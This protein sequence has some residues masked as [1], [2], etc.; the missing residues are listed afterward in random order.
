[1]ASRTQPRSLQPDTG[2]L[3]GLR[4]LAIYAGLAERGAHLL[5]GLLQG[6]PPRQW[7]HYPEDDAV[8]ASGYLWF[9]HAH[10][11][12]DRPGTLEHG[13]V[14]LFARRP[15]WGRRLRS[16]AEQSFAQLCGFPQRDPDTRHLLAIG[17]NAKGLPISLFTVNSWVT[18]DLMLGAAL[19]FELLKRMRLDTGHAEIDGVIEAVV[20]LGLDELRTLLVRR[21]ATL[22]AH[23]GPDKL[24]DERLEL[25][26]EMPLDLDAKL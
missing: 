16:R 25:L 8:D 10:S 26:S 9:Y 11:Q 14:H 2:R 18:G 1:M 19:T 7:A 5:G 24:N 17:F 15:L 12:E 6:Q 3:A 20:Q 23:V 4:L 22:A 13:H 21:D